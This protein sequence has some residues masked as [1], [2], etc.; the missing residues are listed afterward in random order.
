VA[1]KLSIAAGVIVLVIILGYLKWK[2]SP[3]REIERSRDSVAAA[4]S[5]HYHTI[6]RWP[7]YPSETYDADILCPV[8]EHVTSSPTTDDGTPISREYINYLGNVYN[9]VGDRWLSGAGGGQ[10]AAN[11]NIPGRAPIFECLKNLTIGVDETA[12]PYAAIL[13]DGNVRRGGM[14][15][16]DGE[17]CRDYEV[18]VPTPDDPSEKKFQFSLCIN[19][20]D[21]LPRETR[22]TPP[23]ESQEH[24]STY[25]RWNV[26]KEP[27][28][29]PEILSAR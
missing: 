12:L 16:L 27:D 29:P 25:T 20:G 18:S 13:N 6:H 3:F 28:L 21:H 24:I 17:S 4:K 2:Y 26:L 11:A 15:E 5:W 23:G 22:R 1:K 9:H 7:G 14:R 19:E 10:A 8:F